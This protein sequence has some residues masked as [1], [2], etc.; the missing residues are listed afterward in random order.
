MD[1][2]LYALRTSEHW[3]DWEEAALQLDN[4]KELNLW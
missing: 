3:E 4:L 1:D 2:W